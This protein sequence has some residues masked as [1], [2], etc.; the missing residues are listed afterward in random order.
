MENKQTDMEYEFVKSLKKK[1][2]LEHGVRI[3][4]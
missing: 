4:L 1:I 2:D 3:C